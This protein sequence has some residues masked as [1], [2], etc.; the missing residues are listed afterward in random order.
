MT[1]DKMSATP[2]KLV[3]FKECERFARRNALPEQ[4]IMPVSTPS[5]HPLFH[6]SFLTKSEFLIRSCF[7][8]EYNCFLTELCSQDIIGPILE[9]TAISPEEGTSKDTCPEIKAKT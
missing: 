6:S 8:T 2:D 7:A 5:F 9:S 1:S 4:S 3:E